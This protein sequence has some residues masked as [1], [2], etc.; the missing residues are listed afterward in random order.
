MLNV[1]M[2][3]VIMLNVIMLNVIML[4]VGVPSSDFTKSKCLIL[5]KQ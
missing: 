5:S 2:L 1:I 4:S 3:N